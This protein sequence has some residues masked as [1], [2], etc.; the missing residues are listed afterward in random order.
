MPKTAARTKRTAAL[1]TAGASPAAASGSIDDLMAGLGMATADEPKKKKGSKLPTIHVEG[2]EG[3]MK[4]YIDAVAAFKNAEATKA[5]VGGIIKKAAL[6][7]LI[8]HCRKTGAYSVSG[9]VPYAFR[10]EKDPAK[11]Q[12]GAITLK[13]GRYEPAKVDYAAQVNGLKEIFG[14]DFDRFFEPTQDKVLSANFGGDHEANKKIVE[15][16]VKALGPARF[17]EL[18]SYE[19]ALKT[20]RDGGD[21]GDQVIQRE[22]IMSAAMREKVDQAVAKGLVT[23]YDE[24]LTV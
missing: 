9:K 17:K 1:P 11:V 8:E 13:A 18:F 15:E 21:K 23:K 10:D 2:L 24:S 4:E 19:P 16:L 5:D 7:S 14:A 20:K 3:E 6:R 22:A 12:Q